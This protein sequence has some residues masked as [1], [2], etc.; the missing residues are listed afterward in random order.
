[1]QTMQ[2]Q[3]DSRRLAN[4]KAGAKYLCVSEKTFYNMVKDG[5]IPLIHLR[6]ATR[7]DLDDL[8]QL[9]QQQKT[10]TKDQGQ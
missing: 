6:G 10:K 1:M 4:Q 5:Q 7:V 8:D 3:T 9:L 2:P